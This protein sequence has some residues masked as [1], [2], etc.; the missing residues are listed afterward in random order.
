[1]I[2]MHVIISD[3]KKG[4]L[5]TREDLKRLLVWR[6]S[7]REKTSDGGQGYIVHG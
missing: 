6:Q 4:K 2:W 7:Y 1:M 3:S 5:Y